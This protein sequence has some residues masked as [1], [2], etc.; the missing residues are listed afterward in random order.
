MFCFQ[1]RPNY[2][3]RLV[4][5][6]YGYDKDVHMLVLDMFASLSH[7]RVRSTMECIE[8]GLSVVRMLDIS[9]FG[10]NTFLC[11]LYSFHITSPCY[12]M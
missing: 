1:F 12:L 2:A 9:L 11:L 4:M 5:T 7:P 3:N 8:F 6:D 10:V